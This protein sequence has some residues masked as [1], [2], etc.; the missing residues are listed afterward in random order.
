MNEKA[1][2][3]SLLSAILALSSVPAQAAIDDEGMKYVSASEGLSGSI[4]VQVGDTNIEDV[5]TVTDPND[6]R[7][8]YS[9]ESRVDGDMVATYYIE[10]NHA[11]DDIVTY[12]DVGLRGVFG[13]VRLGEIESVSSAILPSADRSGDV[14]TTGF[15]LADDYEQGIR[16]TSPEVVGLV[17]GLSAQMTEELG[18]DKVFDKYDAAFTYRM[19][20]GFSVGASYAVARTTQNDRN[21][22]DDPDDEKGFRIG[23]I[24]EQPR[25]GIGYNYHQYKAFAPLIADGFD[26]GLN[27]YYSSQ[28]SG[29]LAATE[30]RKEKDTEFKEHVIGANARFNRMDFAVSYSKSSVQNENLEIDVSGNKPDV[31]IIRVGADITYNMSSKTKLVMAYS[32][33]HAKGQQL[34]R[35]QI[36]PEKVKEY[37]MLFRVD[38]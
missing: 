24:Y 11:E 27:Y 32:Q 15:K 26:K 2:A 17:V 28:G 18:D 33:G 13:H 29:R 36:T 16:W 37:Y 20:S 31:D 12:T 25:W 7:L 6:T 10:L 8:W 1:I 38:F 35:D 5:N 30:F 34:T 3:F 4:R 22:A 21:N 23:T 19:E 14:G 9:G